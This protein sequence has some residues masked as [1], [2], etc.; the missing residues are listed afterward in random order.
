MR[1]VL[2]GIS[3]PFFDDAACRCHATEQVLVEA[4]VQEAAVQA[5]DEAGDL[6]LPSFR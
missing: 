2:V 1:P 5:L 3:P 4:L 6:E